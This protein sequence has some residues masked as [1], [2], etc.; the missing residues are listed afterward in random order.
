M[1]SNTSRSETPAAISSGRHRVT[2]VTAMSSGIAPSNR[3]IASCLMKGA[4]KNTGSV[5]DDS[6]ASSASPSRNGSELIGGQERFGHLPPVLTH[7]LQFIAALVRHLLN[8]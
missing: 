7:V 2:Q 8:F 5:A 4:I 6:N 3:A 1:R